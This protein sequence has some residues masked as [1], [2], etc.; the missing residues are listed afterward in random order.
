MTVL[1]DAPVFAGIDKHVV[2]DGIPGRCEFRLTLIAP[3]TP[4]PSR[5]H[6]RPY[7]NVHDRKQY[8]WGQ[9]KTAALRSRA[10]DIRRIRKSISLAPG[11]EELSA[12]WHRVWF[13]HGGFTQAFR[14]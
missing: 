5:W 13:A 2:R 1:G 14:G 7:V 9:L 12:G 11:S 6:K 8:R 10:Q 3:F 4:D